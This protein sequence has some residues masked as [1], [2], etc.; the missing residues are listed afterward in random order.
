MRKI[1]ALS[2]LKNML[3][4]AYAPYSNFKV[5]ALIEGEDGEYAC[6]VNVENASYGLT[7]CAERIAMFNFTT[8]GYKKPAKLFLYAPTK[9]FT[10][11]CGAC[12]QVLS[13]FNNNLEIIIFNGKEEF[14][15]YKL[16]DLLPNS[17]N[18]ENLKG[19]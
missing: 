10:P 6:G 3:Q 15:T 17:F 9:D 8:N 14:K 5:A 19:E 12:R 11:P 2:I 13:E 4:N 1:E 18:K 7:V 16:S